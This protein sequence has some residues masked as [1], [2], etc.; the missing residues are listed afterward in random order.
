MEWS[1]LHARHGVTLDMTTR[2]VALGLLLILAASPAWGGVIRGVV[3]LPAIEHR[4]LASLDAYPGQANHI[5]GA[6]P[7]LRGAVTDAVIS[8]DPFPSHAE[9]LAARALAPPQLAQQNQAFAPRVLAVAVGTTVDFP[10]RDPIYHN[11]FSVSPVKRFDLGKYPRGHSKQVTFKKP[12][13]VQVYCDIHAQMAA[14]VLVLPNHGFTRP[15]ASGRFALPDL[16]PGR[17][18]LHA[19]HPDLTAVTREVD[20]P[21]TGEV[22]VPLDF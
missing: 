14:F 1:G 22:N 12:G 19:W 2:K 6:H 21:A 16:P 5:V 15:D 3:R 11:V 20:V 18:T 10:N 4:D 8:I 9:S 7:V 13:L 17:Y